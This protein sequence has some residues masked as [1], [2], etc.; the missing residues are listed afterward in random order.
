M[1]LKRALA[2]L[3]AG[4]GRPAGGKAPNQLTENQKDLLRLSRPEADV[5]QLLR[6]YHEHKKKIKAFYLE[7]GN[8]GY[9]A[10]AAAAVYSVLQPL[11][12]PVTEPLDG[13]KDSRLKQA[14]QKVGWKAEP[15]KRVAEPLAEMLNSEFLA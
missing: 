1:T 4:S 13:G 7:P 12:A 9:P 6:D 5:E 3:A 11:M 2:A 14:L 10:E 15:A 8:A